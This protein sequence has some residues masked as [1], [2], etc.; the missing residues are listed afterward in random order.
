MNVSVILKI[1]VAFAGLLPVFLC[2]AQAAIIVDHTRIS[3]FDQ[4]T[5]QVI[6]DIQAGFSIFYGHTSHGSQLVTGM[7]MLLAEDSRLVYNNGEGT[8]QLYEISDDLGEYGDTSW[9][10]IT[11]SY[12][13]NA[14]Y[15]FNVVIWSWCGGAGYDTEA[16]LQAYL[17]KF[18]ELEN[19][20]PGVTFVYMT[21][22]LNGTG[23]DD[24]IWR[25]NQ[26]IRSYC[27]INNKVLYDFADIESYNPEGIYYE[28][29]TDACNW[30]YDW[31]STHTCPTCVLCAHSHCFNCYQKGKG[32]WWMMAR[33]TGWTPVS[34]VDDENPKLPGRFTLEQNYPNPFNPSTTIEYTLGEASSVTIDIYNLLGE[35]VTN[36]VSARKPAGTYTIQWNGADRFGRAVSSGI[37]F[38]LLRTDGYTETRRMVLSK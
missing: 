23:E 18:T 6:A 25:N 5:S 21:G 10:A 13:N 1:V 31:C 29:E 8:L 14:S 2:S 26:M 28:Y 22:H 3:E 17:D 19:Q 9:A 15:D 7:D 24:T 27:A 30:C 36:L 32:F 38:C 33:L 11:R 37:Y 34:D 35:K 16:G 4:I 20:Y 12:L